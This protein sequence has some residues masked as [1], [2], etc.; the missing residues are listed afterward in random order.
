MYSSAATVD[1]DLDTMEGLRHG[2]SSRLP[3]AGRRNGEVAEGA[4]E[5]RFARADDAAPSS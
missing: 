2:G 4:D 3:P 1:A 5:D